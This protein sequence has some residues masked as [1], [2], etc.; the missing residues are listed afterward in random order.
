ERRERLQ[1]TDW[2]DLHKEQL[3]KAIDITLAAV[4]EHI[5]RFAVLAREMAATESREARRSEL[6]SMAENCELIAHQ[7]PQTFWQALQL[8][9]F[10]QLTLQIES[11][12]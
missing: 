8:C 2:E 11:N 10:I 12:G 5:L 1:L 9:Y 6:L 7:P 3:L 4:S